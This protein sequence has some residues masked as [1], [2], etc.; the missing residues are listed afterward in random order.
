MSPPNGSIT[1]KR[2]LF[3]S[4]VSDIDDLRAGIHAVANYQ[5]T[6]ACLFSASPGYTSM[7]PYFLT[8]MGRGGAYRAP[9]R[10]GKHGVPK[11]SRTAQ[12][13]DRVHREYRGKGKRKRDIR[14]DE[15]AI[16]EGKSE[17]LMGEGSRDRRGSG[18]GN[19]SES[20]GDVVV[21]RDHDLY[22]MGGAGMMGGPSGKGNPGMGPIRL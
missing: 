6:R 17:E 22:G 5:Q 7:S 12:P 10:K 18:S 4:L 15:S 3:H 1:I 11:I 21:Y 16:G 14:S 8:P 20:E 9:A 19:E 2:S 13:V